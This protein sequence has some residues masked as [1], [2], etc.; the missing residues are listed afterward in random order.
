MV[1]AF[2]F[3]L[4]TTLTLSTQRQVDWINPFK[5]EKNE[6]KLKRGILYCLVAASNRDAKFTYGDKYEASI[7]T[8][9]HIDPSMV[10]P[11]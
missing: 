6:F 4:K 11:E 3:P 9:D 10:Q 2:L 8:F 5:P 7:F 1:I